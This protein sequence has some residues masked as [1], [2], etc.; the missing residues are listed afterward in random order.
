LASRSAS[1]AEKMGVGSTMPSLRPFKLISAGKFETGAQPLCQNRTHNALISVSMICVPSIPAP[2]SVAA[3]ELEH[4]S[5]AAAWRE[6][7]GTENYSEI[8][9]TRWV[10]GYE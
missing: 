10:W 3:V 8:C 5:V 4:L 9:S 2:T 1:W 7:S 6:L